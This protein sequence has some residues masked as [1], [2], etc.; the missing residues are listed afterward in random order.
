MTIEPIDAGRTRMSI[1]STF[2]SAEAMEQVLGMGMEEGLTQAVGQIDAILAEIARLDGRR[3]MTTLTD[4]TT[5]TIEVPGAV[6]TYDVRSADSAAPVL[7]MI[8]SPMGAGGFVTLAG[9]FAD[10]TI[11]TYD[12]RGVERS[13]KDDPATPST[14]EQHADDL[15]RIIE[16]VGMGPVDIFASSGGAVNALALVA[17]HPDQVRTSSPMSRHWRPSCP[18]AMVRWPS[19]RRSTT[20]TSEAG[21]A[22][23][24]RSSSWP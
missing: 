8:G 10:R 9:H 17:T 4:P 21:S 7:L 13:P 14:P 22:P 11:V 15:H 19:P 2:P 3:P 6:L 20:P 23:G 18:T 12:P 24:W 1:K 5:H 16:A